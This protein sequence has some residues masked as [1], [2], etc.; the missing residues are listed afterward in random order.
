MMADASPWRPR[1]EQPGAHSLYLHIPFCARKCA[2]CD[3]ASWETQRDDGLLVAY[4]DALISQIGEARELG[5]LDDVRTAYVG[6]GTPTLLGEGIG[7]LVSEVFS[8]G[9]EEL[10][11]EANP[12]SLDD[13][14]LGALLD[15]GTTRLSIGVQSLNDGELRTLGRVH[16]AC[17]AKE[18]VTA[19]V[20]SGVDVSCDLMCALPGQTAATWAETLGGIVGL[21]VGHVS[22]Y[23]LMIEE[24][25]AF[26][27]RYEDDSCDWNSD[28]VQAT[29]ME[30][31]KAKLEGNEFKR[32]EVASYAKQGKR[33][34]HNIAY[35]T[36]RPY[37]GLG[38]RASSMLTLKGYLRLSR[39]C[40]SLPVAPSGTSRVRLTVLNSRAQIASEPS[41]ASLRFSLDF[42]S[43]PQSAAEDLMLGARLADGLDPG[44]VAHAREVLGCNVVDD[45]LGGLLADGYLSRAGETYVPTNRGWLL[46]NEL[47]GR[48][49]DLA[50][51]DVLEA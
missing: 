18:R 1:L 32:Y 38:T 49:W 40:E 36:G 51:G 30:K 33:C 11:C 35:W 9:V 10:S 8:L 16:D 21:G 3:F 41:L 20:A 13:S 47:Y 2:Y 27:R 39:R 14:T 25:T 31:A 26:E 7:P 46:G 12:D 34:K 29:C 6:G 44:L 50:P 42:L 48:L 24:G 45:C 15:C 17:T 5:L 28:E 37:L 43:E 23:P 4:R 19:A 22:V